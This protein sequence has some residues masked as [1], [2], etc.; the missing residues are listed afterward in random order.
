MTNRS[1]G[2]EQEFFQR[3]GILSQEFAQSRS[4]FFQVS[5]SLRVVSKARE[6]T[7][8]VQAPCPIAL[9]IQH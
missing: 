5:E 9:P 1:Q 3:F 7:L 6:H 2:R 4:I 8:L